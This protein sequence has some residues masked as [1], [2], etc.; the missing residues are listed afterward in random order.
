MM[1]VRKTSIFP[2]HCKVIYEKLQQIE[3]LQYIAEPYATFTPVN[4]YDPMMWQVGASSSY[5]FKMW[6][7]I[8][9][10]IHTINIERFDID[11]VRSH[12]ENKYVPIWNH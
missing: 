4:P 7:I 1:T 5:R 3:T 12:E 6:G 9:F 11:V 10:G 2:A 8:P